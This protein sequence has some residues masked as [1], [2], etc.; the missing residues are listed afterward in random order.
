MSP[1]KIVTSVLL[2]VVAAF[3]LTLLYLNEGL[4][5]GVAGHFPTMLAAVEVEHEDAES[6]TE[7]RPRTISREHVR[8]TL[9]KTEVHQK[10]QTLSVAQ[11]TSTT[12]IVDTSAR[13]T[14]AQDFNSFVAYVLAH[15]SRLSSV[16]IQDGSIS[17][18]YQEPAKLVWF[19]D[20]TV[21]A[22]IASDA[23]GT[24]RV[25]YPW[26][27]VFKSTDY[28]AGS[29]AYTLQSVIDS[30]RQRRIY[31]QTKVGATSTGIVFNASELFELITRTL[32]KGKA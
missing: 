22:H 18:N 16:D 17:L 19:V 6:E 25:T 8:Q 2:L 1:I 29:L 13:V 12:P 9:Q 15:D 3:P 10:S 7:S 23:S 32:K 21:V 26:S 31:E 4:L 11:A 30:E 27:H 14:T 24:V 20:S 28:S 5:N